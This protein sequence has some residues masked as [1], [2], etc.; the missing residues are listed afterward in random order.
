MSKQERPKLGDRIEFRRRGVLRVGT[1][2]AVAS[3]GVYF[4]VEMDHPKAGV[5]RVWDMG[6]Q[7]IRM[8]LSRIARIVP[9]EEIE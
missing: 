1:I 7:Q 4:T 2:V 9:K 8:G 5:R 3:P 6:K